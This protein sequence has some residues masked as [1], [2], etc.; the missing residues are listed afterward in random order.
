[1]LSLVLFLATRPITLDEAVALA[2]QKNI[3]LR[4]SAVE[5]RRA[6]DEAA[7]SAGQLL[8]RLS[9]DDVVQVYDSNY[10]L[11]FGGTEFLVRDQITNSL[12][13]QATQPLFGL[14][15][16]GERWRS[17]RRLAD[18]AQEDHR[19]ARNDIVFR[20]TESYLRVLEAMD[21]A[22][23]AE[24]TIHDIE[25]QARTARALVAAGTLIEADYLRT[26]VALAQARQDLLRA[27]AQLGSARAQLAAVIGDRKSV[28]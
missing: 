8:P 23:I 26:Q 11:L 18:A 1:M 10:A 17:Q 19:A 28:V 14:Y 15:P 9:A 7:E 25:E 27:Q 22:T 21:L 16:L 3:E 24:Q 20:T 2:K 5:T 13:L 4:T 6:A 12:T